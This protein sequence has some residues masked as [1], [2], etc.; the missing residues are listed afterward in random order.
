M[1]IIITIKT[2]SNKTYISSEISE[3]KFLEDYIDGI[4]DIRNV[5]AFS[6]SLPDNTI[7]YF[8]PNNIDSINIKQIKD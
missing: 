4:S 7:E 5:K 6:I 8:N 1:N 2:T 3:E